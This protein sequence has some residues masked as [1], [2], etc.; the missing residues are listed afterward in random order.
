MERSE[1]TLAGIGRVAS[2]PD[3]VPCSSVENK[4]KKESGHFHRET[5]YKSLL[6]CCHTNQIACWGGGGQRSKLHAVIG[7]IPCILLQ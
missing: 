1:Y 7:Q 5:N 6:A 2:S 3:H 4:K